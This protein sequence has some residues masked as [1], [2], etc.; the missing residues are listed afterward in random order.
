[1]V[2]YFVLTLSVKTVKERKNMKKKSDIETA[3]RDIYFAGRWICDSIPVDKQIELLEKLRDAAGIP[4]RSATKMNV[5]A[6]VVGK[7]Q[8]TPKKKTHSGRIYR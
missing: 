5:G 8:Y 7:F 2:N 3:V 6:T 1:M 4:K